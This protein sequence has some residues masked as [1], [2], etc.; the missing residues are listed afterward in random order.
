MK[1]FDVI[2]NIWRFKKASFL[3]VLTSLCLVSSHF[4]NVFYKKVAETQDNISSYIREREYEFAENIFKNT[5]MKATEDAISVI[6]TFNISAYEVYANDKVIFQWP[7]NS[8]QFL[9]QC[10]RLFE[11]EI[12]LGGILIS[13]VKT[14]LST[15]ALVQGTF[16]TTSFLL[17]FILVAL[18]FGIVAIQ[19]LTG[20]KKSLNTTIDTL[21][22]WNDNPTLSTPPKSDD[23]ETNKVIE[24][25]SRGVESR[26]ELTEVQTQLG[27]EKELSRVIRQLAHD[28]RDPICSLMANAKIVS[29][30]LEKSGE[31]K[32]K[33]TML[34]LL[35]Y[36]ATNI[37][38]IVEDLLDTHRNGSL[39]LK[40]RMEKVDVLKICKDI[41]SSKKITNS[42]IDF[43]VQDS[44]DFSVMADPKEI[45]RVFQNIINNSID[46]L[47]KRDK[48]IRIISEQDANSQK[49]VI[50][51]NG[52]GISSEDLPKVFGEYFSKGKNNGSGLGLYYVKKKIN[53]WG[54]TVSID[55]VFGASTSVC[56]EFNRSKLSEVGLV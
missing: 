16:N 6:R 50:E 51:D 25:L 14:C 23:L 53:S 18:I 41:V 28:I 43:D 40:E 34:P 26:M 3:I 38:G 48:K 19:P 12:T 36:S 45:K 33:E 24:L 37:E 9:S 44:A 10:D 11:T 7:K 35:K 49:I 42:N 22:K 46:A 55:S 13:P 1:F 32:I 27:M 52:K 5:N 39:L 8:S 15:S 20:Y 2:K 56:I 30:I 31:T 21:K 4:I 47:D 17:V 54:G 29:E